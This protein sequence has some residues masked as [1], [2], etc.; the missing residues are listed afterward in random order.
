MEIFSVIKRL[1]GHITDLVFPISCLVCGQDGKYLCEQCF[2]KLPKLQKQQ[3]LVCQKPSPFGKTHPECASRNKVDG[4]LS[5]LTHKDKY[6]HKIIWV[7]KYNFV[8]TLAEP[9]AQLIT[10]T[11]SQQR[12]D[13]Y[14]NEFIVVPVPLHPRRFN[15]RGFNQAELLAQ[16]LS[17]KLNICMKESLIVRNKFTKPQVNLNAEERKRNLEN[18]FNL[19]GDITN[20]KILL[21]DDVITSG[22]TANEMAKILKQGKATEVW[23]VS[24]A[25]G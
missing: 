6:V 11:I 9:L 20:K 18:A 14:F 24:A 15:W 2:V 7:F 8:S 19:L 16:A 23:I 12:L 25:H 17:E 13:N 1:G 5:A 3:C 10:E 21:V 22:S 4:A